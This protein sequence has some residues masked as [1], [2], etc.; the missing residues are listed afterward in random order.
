M[1]HQNSIFCLK[2]DEGGDNKITIYTLDIN[3]CLVANGN[4][5]DICTNTDGSRE[6]S[7]EDGYRLEDD[8][9]G[10]LGWCIETCM[11][12]VHTIHPPARVCL[13]SLLGFFTMLKVRRAGSK[14]GGGCP[15]FLRN[16]I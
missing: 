2:M 16:S 3:E 4:C 6:C 8:G 5:E 14:G 10:C 1:P 7:C 13:S 11:S 9:Q 12:K 15:P